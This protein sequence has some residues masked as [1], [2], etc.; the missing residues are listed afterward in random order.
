M[1]NVVH[2]FSAPVVIRRYLHSVHW[3]VIQAKKLI[4]HSY[5]LRGKY[6]N[7]YYNRDPLDANI[8]KIFQVT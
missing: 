4:E 3:D 5:T 8:Q 6:P 1:K 2:Y 7:I